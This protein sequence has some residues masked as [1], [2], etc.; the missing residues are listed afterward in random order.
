MMNQLRAA[1]LVKADRVHRRVYTDPEIYEAEMRAIFAK[2]WVF[3]GH[4][5]QVPRPG[6]YMTD[7]LVGQP[8]LMVRDE[9]G[10]VHVFFNR[11]THRGA[12]LCRLSEGQTKSFQCPYHGWTFGTD[13]KLIGVPLRERFGADFA[14]EDWGLISPPRVDSYQGF[15]FVSLNPQVPDLKDHLG[16]VCEYL[17][18]MVARAPEGAIEAVKPLKYRFSGNWKLQLENYADNYHPPFAHRSAFEVGAKM[19]REKYGDKAYSVAHARAK[20]FEERSLPRGH[21][22]ANFHGTRDP[23][24]REAYDS[25]AYIDA[26]ARRHGPER[27]KELAEADIHIIIY[28][29]LLLHT[30]LNHYRVIKP[31]AVD[32]TE[33]HTYP[34]KLKGAPEEINQAIVR[35]TS[36]HVSA[37]GEVQVDDL[38]MFVRVQEGLRAEA[39]EWVLIK[40]RG[41]EEHSEGAGETVSYGASELLLRGFYKEW[42]RLMSEAGF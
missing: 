10:R 12:L 21:G 2:T 17:D 38:E 34:C 1:E 31:L 25:Q 3:V 13:G 14:L 4:E 35:L 41:E 15:V 27:A 19:L 26:L 42:V 32:Q 11:C 33:I 23:I 7:T 40:M 16:R 29:N 36:H 37:G 6:D 28:P 30:R 8:I 24:W 18:L 22:I 20:K 39:V 5:S 9:Q